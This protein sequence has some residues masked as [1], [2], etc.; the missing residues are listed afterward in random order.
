[1]VTIVSSANEIS[2]CDVEETC[3]QLV[4]ATVIHVLVDAHVRREPPVGLV[5]KIKEIAM[6]EANRQHTLQQQTL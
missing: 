5:M 1:M 4:H 6:R 3:L 2:A